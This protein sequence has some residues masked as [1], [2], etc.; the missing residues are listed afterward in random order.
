MSDGHKVKSDENSTE[1]KDESVEKMEV[2]SNDTEKS[3]KSVAENKTITEKSSEKI[4]SETDNEIGDK[5]ET[6]SDPAKVESVNSSKIENS[7]ENN[8]SQ[9]PSV[10]SKPVAVVEPSVPATGAKTP[11]VTVS[12]VEISDITSTVP[13]SPAKVEEKPVTHALVISKSPE[14]VSND[15]KVNSESVPVAKINDVK[16]DLKSDKVAA[17]KLFNY[18]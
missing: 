13:E 1:K 11:E 6:S 4:V 14:V 9:L 8:K 5:P 12:P 17:C 16:A 2:D 10:Q 7:I 15:L 3:V 18:R